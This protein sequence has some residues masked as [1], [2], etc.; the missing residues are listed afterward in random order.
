M[1][2]PL[3]KI[4]KY[5]PF[6]NIYIQNVTYLKTK[7][8]RTNFFSTRLFTKYTLSRFVEKHLALVF[9]DLVEAN[10]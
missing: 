1:I 6:N 2:F 4:D 5:F 7:T 8:S 3:P 10:A 9:K